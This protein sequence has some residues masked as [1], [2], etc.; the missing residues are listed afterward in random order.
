[1]LLGI[2][3]TPDIASAARVPANTP[4]T[5]VASMLL[6]PASL[7]THPFRRILLLRTPVTMGHAANGRVIGLLFG[8]FCKASS[9]VHDLVTTV[10]GCSAESTWRTSNRVFSGLVLATHVAAPA[11]SS[12]PPPS[13]IRVYSRRRGGGMRRDLPSG[14]RFRLVSFGSGFGLLL[15]AP[16]RLCLQ[17]PE[18]HLPTFS[19][20]VIF[21]RAPVLPNCQHP[22]PN[23]SLHNL[24]INGGLGVVISN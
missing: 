9:D 6:P 8:A 22:A 19:D 7:Q 21:C 5:H 23:L 20:N 24:R 18:A 17:L 14:P 16:S 13:L 4:P 2:I 3:P 11:L 12:Q 15:H 1:M 10:G